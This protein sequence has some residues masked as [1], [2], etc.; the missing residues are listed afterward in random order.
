MTF[1]DSNNFILAFPPLHERYDKVIPV[2]GPCYPLPLLLDSS[3]IVFC[4]KIG[5][6]TKG[7]RK[8]H[9]HTPNNAVVSAFLLLFNHII[10]GDHSIA[11][12]WKWKNYY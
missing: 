7:V 10:S 1:P 8:N 12:K 2:N 3:D 11:E 4:P 5:G 9:V 6:E